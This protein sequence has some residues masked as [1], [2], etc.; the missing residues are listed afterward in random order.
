ML[1]SCVTSRIVAVGGALCLALGSLEHGVAA[2][3]QPLS[4]AVAPRQN[5][6]ADADLQLSPDF[7]AIL[8]GRTISGVVTSKTPSPIRLSI[9]S[10]WWISDQVA[11]LEQFGN[12]F[13]QEWIAYPLQPGQA[14]RVDLLVNRQQWSLLDYFQRYQFVNKFSAIARSFGY[15]MRVYDHPDRPPVAL[16]ACDFSPVAATVLQSPP[17]QISPQVANATTAVRAELVNEL[18]CQLQM[19]GMANSLKR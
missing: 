17:P 6:L 15:N 5:L 8:A 10:L 14:G 9:P 7:R 16:Y 3:V 11:A 19:A 13:I 12:K 18:S 2:E 4:P 1:K